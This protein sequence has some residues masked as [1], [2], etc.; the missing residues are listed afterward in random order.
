MKKITLNR[1]VRDKKRGTIGEIVTADDKQICV[2]LELPYIDNKDDIS[3]IPT[4]TYECFQR[5]SQRNNQ[6]IGGVVYELKAVPNRGNIQLH[7]GNF[8]SNTNGCILVGRATDLRT[9]SQSTEAMQEL[10]NYLGKENFTL[11]VKD[12]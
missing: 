9:I 5:I 3:C 8:L 10:I 2:T 11:E 4:G 7:I 12:V 1:I 6:R